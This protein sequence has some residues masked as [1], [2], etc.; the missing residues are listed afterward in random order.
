FMLKI[1]IEKTEL[2]TGAVI[3]LNQQ[4]EIIGGYLNNCQITFNDTIYE[5]SGV[6][7]VTDPNFVFGNSPDVIG[8]L[9]YVMG[10]DTCELQVNLPF[11]VEGHKCDL[12]DILCEGLITD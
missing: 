2:P 7:H 12:T 4:M 10:S 1:Q 9:K 6:L 5:V 3:P 8:Y 11:F